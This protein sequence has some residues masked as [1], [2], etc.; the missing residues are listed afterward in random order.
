MENTK[1][2]SKCQLFKS[3]NE[4][5]KNKTKS[6]G[7]ASECKLCKKSMDKKYRAKPGFSEKRK[8]YD[9]K[10]TEN[11]KDKVLEA[12]AKWRNENKEY[13][14]QLILEWRIKNPNKRRIE[15]AK[16]R[17]AKL[18]AIPPWFEKDKVELIYQKAMEWNMTVDHVVPLQG[19]NV[20]GL[21]CWDNLQLLDISLNSAKSNREYP[22][23]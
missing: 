4:F 5:S 23:H 11:N 16:Y 17:S 18:N 1:K 14:K 12:K 20:C 7:L 13:Q 21:H 22:D 2:C 10:Y 8:Q 9:Q 6:F 3:F 15:S 19:E